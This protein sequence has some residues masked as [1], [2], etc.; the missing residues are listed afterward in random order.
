MKA[1]GIILK[2]Y[3]NPRRLVFWLPVSGA[4][5][6]QIYLTIMWVASLGT[7]R[8][9]FPALSS[10]ALGTMFG[11]FFGIMAAVGLH[12]RQT[13]LEGEEADLLP[14]YHVRQATTAG[15]I[16]TAI[17]F[18]FLALTLFFEWPPLPAL[19][20]FLCITALTL[21]FGFYFLG[22]LVLIF[23]PMAFAALFFPDNRINNSLI[24]T[25]QAIWTGV[26]A[27]GNMRTGL[28]IV[29]SFCGIVLLFVRYL[30]IDCASVGS[31]RFFIV[32]A[33]GYAK[34]KQSAL[35]AEFTRFFSQE[36]KGLRADK[37][38]EKAVLQ[39]ADS[40]RGKTP[41][42]FQLTRLIR[43]AMSRAH[44]SRYGNSRDND[45][46]RMI[47]ACF[48][49]LAV[50]LGAA[51]SSRG[52]PDAPFMLPLFYF[53]TAAITITAFQRNKNQLPLLY[54]QTCLPSRASFMKAAAA[55]YLLSAAESFLICMGAALITH[56]LLPC[57]A[58]PYMFQ[59]VFINAAMVLVFASVLFLSGNQQ[60]TQPDDQYWKI[61]FLLIFV[62]FM[63]FSLAAGHSTT[64]GWIIT[65]ACVLAGTLIFYAA[66][67]RWTKSEMD[68]A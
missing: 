47:A 27:P 23:I 41:S 20:G 28:L 44:V 17:L 48:G 8:M 38:I 66:L 36:R 5:G 65:G 21:W 10:Y 35:S 25:Y 18:I 29:Q 56:F 43:L 14:D 67:R 64:V 45:N 13:L 32:G 61:R 12:L 2:S 52:I 6:V 15:I 39:M 9:Y 11:F 50:V 1:V 4:V 63:C 54:L 40:C 19:A 34:V 57:L 58:W 24:E 53:L 46:M 49:V 59:I 51:T 55:G 42:F 3:I 62:P 7:E 26:S 68:C 16:I 33:H 31:Y 60:K 30:N 37:R 22:V